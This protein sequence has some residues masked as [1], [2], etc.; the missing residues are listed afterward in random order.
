MMKDESSRTVDPYRPLFDLDEKS[1]VYNCPIFRL[2][3]PDRWLLRASDLNAKLTDRQARSRKATT[4][5]DNRSIL[6]AE[7]IQPTGDVDARSA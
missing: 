7:I 5:I 6:R 3:D 4:T 2:P 1:P